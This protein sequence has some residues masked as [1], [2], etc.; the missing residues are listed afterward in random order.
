M[1]PIPPQSAYVPL[2]P[3]LPPYNASLRGPLPRFLPAAQPQVALPWISSAV[4]PAPVLSALA[5][6]PVALLQAQQPV[7]VQ[8]PVQSP[9]QAVASVTPK[10]NQPQSAAVVA[11]Q[12]SSK[13]SVDPNKQVED[14]DYFKSGAVGAVLGSIISLGHNAAFGNTGL[15]G[16]L[17]EMAG[18]PPKKDS[19]QYVYQTWGPN[20][21]HC[22]RYETNGRHVSKIYRTPKKGLLAELTEN[23]RPH[24]EIEYPASGLPLP[25]LGGKP[26]DAPPERYMIRMFKENGESVSKLVRV[27]PNETEIE[28]FSP[29]H[30]RQVFKRANKGTELMLHEH[31]VRENGKWQ[32]AQKFEPVWEKGKLMAREV[33]DHQGPLSNVLPKSYGKLHL[34]QLIED[35]SHVHPTVPSSAQRMVMRKGSQAIRQRL[36]NFRGLWMGAA[37]GAIVISFG[38]LINATNTSTKVN[39][40]FNGIG[41]TPNL[42]QA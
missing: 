30:T 13:N 21:G 7:Q 39:L 26:S 29:A 9:A 27:S 25:G 36:L 20:D 1:L 3:P 18:M 19:E 6:P 32:L 42:P 40:S 34:P 14:V 24:A 5:A 12:A 16:V 17:R 28:A 41:A 23:F 2:Q 31:Y 35:L 37:V 4:V 38:N 22:Y 10:A 33:F 8:A 15:I 11:P